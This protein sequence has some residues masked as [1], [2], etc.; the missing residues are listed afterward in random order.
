V[1]Y[2][3]SVMFSSFVSKAATISHAIKQTA[4]TICSVD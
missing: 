3:L 4:A 1:Y 2:R